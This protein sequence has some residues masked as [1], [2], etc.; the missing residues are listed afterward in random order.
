MH[1]S[2]IEKEVESCATNLANKT[3]AEKREKNYE[4]MW[5]LL[6]ALSVE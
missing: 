5:C 6:L 4:D 3:N 1:G 2:G